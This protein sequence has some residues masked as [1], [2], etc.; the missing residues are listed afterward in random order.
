MK[1]R[2]QDTAEV[3]A[4]APGAW[5]RGRLAVFAALEWLSALR[6]PAA[7]APAASA[8]TAVT[9]IAGRPAAAPAAAAGTPTPAPA[10]AQRPSLWLFV[11]T[12]GELNAIDPFL[13]PLLEALG[14]PPLT[15]I[16]DRTTYDEAYRA[17]YPKAAVERLDGSTAA[18]NALARR[19]PPL[20]LLVAEI[21]CRL[22]DAPCRFSYS[23]VHAARRAGAPALLVNGWLYG[24]PPPSR[25]DVLENRWFAIDY[26][27][28]FDL[29]LVQTE[30]VR[31]ALCA[32]GAEPARVAVTGNIKF[33]A[34]NP[35]QLPPSALADTLRARA[36]G[37]VIVAG[38]VTETVHQQALVH[39]F[40]QVLQ[41]HPGALLV[42]APRHPEN[43]PRMAALA[44]CLRASGLDWRL[45][46]AHGDAAAAAGGAVLVLDT[47]GELRGCY[48][49]ATLAFVG[50]DHNVL[51]PLAYGKPVFVSAPWEETY[52]SYPV[53]RQLLDA[54]VLHA[55]DALEGLGSAWCAMLAGSAG[56]RAADGERLAQVLAEKRGA[57]ARNL[58]AI[59][60]SGLLARLR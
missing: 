25:I 50:N 19:R 21:P 36:G 14:Q 43:A 40:Q 52:P 26:L 47:M 37:P 11:S 32:A 13:G 18:A 48:A 56:D 55:V 57:V 45:R 7:A 34:M 58:C 44:E 17:R 35:A 2:G 4:P 5:T 16:S 15:L 24:Y 38:S 22:H 59:R 39:A 23:T 53:Y 28:A 1:V 46:S 42:L 60:S 12:I 10:S 8:A 20:L 54:G 27:R 9:A 41:Q 31:G 6:R 49:A 33:D 30:A 29:M 51:E 3:G